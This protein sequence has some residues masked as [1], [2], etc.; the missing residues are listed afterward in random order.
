MVE[1][2]LAYKRFVFGLNLSS[3]CINALVHYL[4]V[5]ASG[6]DD[7]SSYRDWL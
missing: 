3:L 6:F 4:H 7:G 1:T 5:Q 2:A